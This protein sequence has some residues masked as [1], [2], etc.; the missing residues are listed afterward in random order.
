MQAEIISVGT[1]LL[2]GDIVDTNASYI[3]QRLAW[4]GIDLFRKATVGDN[5]ER[6]IK[7]LK[8]SLERVDLVII[9]GGLGPTEDDITKEVVSR[10]MG[11]KLILNKEIVQQIKERFPHGKR[12]QKAIFKQAL[13]PSSAKIVPNRVG[14]APGIIFEEKNKIIILL[15]GVPQEMQTMMKDEIVPYLTVKIKSG[16][17]IR[18]KVLKIC[19]MGETQVEKEI[20]SSLL[21]QSN[22]TIALLAKGGEVHIRITAK[23]P[24]QIV[25]NKIKKV[26][27]KLRN[28][29]KDYIYGVNEETL[30]EIA[31]SLL[32]KKRLTISVAESC[33]GG[34]VSHRLTNISGSSNY[35]KCGIISYSN[36]AKSAFLKVDSQLIKEKEAVSS[37]VAIEMAV[38][39]RTSAHTDIGLGITG[40]AGPTG[41]T[42]RKPVGLVYIA[43][44]SQTKEI[45]QRFIFSGNR[46]QI[47]W[48]SSQAALDI[49]RKYLMRVAS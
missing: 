23:F 19:G 24:P 5:R 30:E 15:P 38:G 39:I 27:D 49:L 9:T 29:L 11:K 16:Q 41:A 6:L 40:I 48:K 28:R 25:N 34:L 21:S 7:T 37:E 4:L 32:I 36:Q 46:E 12:M 10:L 17:S 43:L 3:A 44:S 31:A 14:T 26:E 20:P 13:I 18:S 22:P 42:P 35:Y 2:L 45:C 33:T 1:E 47:K 8:E